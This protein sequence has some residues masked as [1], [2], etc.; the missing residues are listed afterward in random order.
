MYICRSSINELEAFYYL[1]LLFNY[2]SQTF[3]IWQHI[4]I[5][6][7]YTIFGYLSPNAKW[8]STSRS[9]SDSCQHA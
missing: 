6:F 4:S 5:I 1:Y 3:F 7:V 9:G 2:L 8:S